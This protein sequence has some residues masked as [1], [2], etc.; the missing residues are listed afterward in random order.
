MALPISSQ[1][2]A[3]WRHHGI[4]EQNDEDP[5]YRPMAPDF[6]GDA[7]KAAEELVLRGREQLNGY[8]ESILHAH[9]RAVKAGNA[10]RTL[11]SPKSKHTAARSTPPGTTVK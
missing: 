6:S 9:R 4:V 8:T 7:F 3:N 5:L 10:R 11:T 1:H 2:I